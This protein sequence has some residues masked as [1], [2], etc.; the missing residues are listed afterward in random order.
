MRPGSWLDVGSLSQSLPGSPSGYRL[1]QSREY[2][3][4]KD[5]NEVKV[6]I[7]YLMRHLDCPLEYWQVNDIVVQDGYVDDL[8]FSDC[9]FELIAADNIAVVSDRSIDYYVITE[10]GK[11]VSDNL[12]PGIS[13]YIREK[14]LRSAIRHLSYTERGAKVETDMRPAPEGRV[15][16]TLRIVERERVILDV[17]IYAESMNQAKLMCHNFKQDPDGMFKVIF[18]RLTNL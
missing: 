14:S 6:F 8:T 12:C 5:R 3:V 18:M 2:M 15:E 1:Q 13:T 7:L 9:F 17:K 4:F 16:V 10:Q 11:R